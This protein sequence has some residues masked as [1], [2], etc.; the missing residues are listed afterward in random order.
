MGDGADI[1]ESCHHHDHRDDCGG[2]ELMYGSRLTGVVGD[3]HGLFSFLRGTGRVPWF[4]WLGV[5]PWAV[6]ARWLVRDHRGGA[7]IWGQAGNRRFRHRL[8]GF[9]HRDRGGCG[10]RG[11]FILEFGRRGGLAGSPLDWLLP[12]PVGGRGPLA[13]RLLGWLGG[14]GRGFRLLVAGVLI[15]HALTSQLLLQLESTRDEWG[16]RR[17][18]PDHNPPAG[19]GSTACQ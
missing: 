14:A 2:P 19:H 9:R 1:Q 7:G 17:G 3:R 18:L 5:F 16:D 10:R 11:R 13:D 6:L 15:G 12:L 8:G 4:G